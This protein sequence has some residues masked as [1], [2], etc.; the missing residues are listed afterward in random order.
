[1]TTST[2]A[3]NSIV[4]ADRLN[5]YDAIVAGFTT[6]HGGTSQSPF[7]SFNLGSTAG[8][9]AEHVVANRQKLADATGFPLDRIVIAGQ[10][11]GSDVLLV[12]QPGVYR[13]YDGLV[14]ATPDLL[15]CI[16]A[17]DCAAV[18]MADVEAGVIGACHSGW[19]GAVAGIAIR[20]VDIMIARG[21]DP[22]RI[23]A[24]VSPCI[25]RAHF[26]VGPEVAEKFDPEFVFVPNGKEKPHVDLKGAVARQL[27][28]AGLR[29]DAIEVS[30]RCTFGE[31][32]DFFSYRKEGARSGRMMGFIGIRSPR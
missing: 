29:P 19:R 21:A 9:N 11:H 12:D 3:S 13:G 2:D 18:L 28:Q 32:T 4:W 24:F 22:G 25:S 8:D 16:T 14:T 30:D 20:T 10:V 31:A 27:D 26:E 1:M 7:T 15:L 5:K 17:A 23:E 6:R